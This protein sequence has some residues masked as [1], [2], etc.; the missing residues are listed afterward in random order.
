MFK[1]LAV[2]VSLLTLFAGNAFSAERYKMLSTAQPTSSPDKVEVVEL[3]WYGCNHCHDLEPVLQ[4]W[5]KTKAD[6]I[7]YVRVPAVFRENWMPL[8]RAW[9]LIDTLELGDQVHLNLFKAIHVKKLNMNNLGLL[10]SFFG[11]QGVSAEQ[12]DKVYNSFSI[13]SQVRN[14][15]KLTRDYQIT[16]VPAIIVNGRYMTSVSLT[17]SHQALMDEVDALAAKEAEVMGL[18]T[19]TE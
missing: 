5:L 6:Y 17:G 16:G 11:N 4:Q 8:A 1:Q 14:A 19:A 9:Y 10:R 7:E 3:F 15:A 12:F 18:L 13:D 2:V